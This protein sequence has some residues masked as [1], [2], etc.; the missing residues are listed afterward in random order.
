MFRATTIEKERRRNL[1]H[2]LAF[3]FSGYFYFFR[4]AKTEKEV[5]EIL[6]PVELS[7]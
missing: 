6:F 2:P 7:K 3:Q 5:R 1:S 4:S